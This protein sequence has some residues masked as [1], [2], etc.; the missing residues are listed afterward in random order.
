M[1]TIKKLA[2]SEMAIARRL[3]PTVTVFLLKKPD[4]L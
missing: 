2:S 1:E 4:Q 3:T